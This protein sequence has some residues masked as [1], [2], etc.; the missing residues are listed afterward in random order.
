MSTSPYFAKA[1]LGTNGRPAASGWLYA[2]AAGSTVP[3]AIF[4]DYAKTIPLANPLRLDGSGI[5]P[6]FFTEAGLYDF[7]VFEYNFVTPDYPGPSCFTAEDIDG[8]TGGGGSTYVLPIATETILGGVKPDGA[9]NRAEIKRLD[10]KTKQYVKVKLN[11]EK[12]ST[13]I[14]PDDVITV[15]KKRM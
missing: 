2:Y 14:E 7:K 15:P 12:G 4:A 6:Q 11:K 13:L 1:F 10:P 5:C 9:Q 3:K 8:E